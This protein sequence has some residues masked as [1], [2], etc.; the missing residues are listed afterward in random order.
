MTLSS[1]LLGILV[2][3]SCAILA[4]QIWIISERTSI[5]HVPSDATLKISPTDQS[6]HPTRATSNP[7]PKCF[8]VTNIPPEWSKDN[9][10]KSLREIE[11]SLDHFDGPVS[12]YPACCDTTSQTA[13]LNLKTCPEFLQ[14]IGPG[15]TKSLKMQGQNLD[16]TVVLSVDSHFYGLTPLNTPEGEIVAELV[17]SFAI[18]PD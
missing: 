1:L 7:G 18:V 2:L 16:K 14:D 4:L 17:Y 8:R 9:L 3:L 13:L 6:S 5:P 15:D 10:L 12:L 11:P